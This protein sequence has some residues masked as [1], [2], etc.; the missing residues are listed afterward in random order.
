MDKVYNLDLGRNSL[1]TV[2][3][4]RKL[5]RNTA[6]VALHVARSADKAAIDLGATCW[7]CLKAQP[8]RPR[9]KLNPPG[10][11]RHVASTGAWQ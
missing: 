5:P 8:A 7:A 3:E 4:M 9:K 2:A 10:L 6:P 11:A 1:K